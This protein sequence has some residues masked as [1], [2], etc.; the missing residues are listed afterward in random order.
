MRVS[1]LNKPKGL[2]MFRPTYLYIKTHNI[3]GLKYFG[4]TIK[5]PFKYKGSGKHWCAHLEKHGCD[6]TTEILGYYTNKEECMNAALE[7]SDKNKIVESSDWANMRIEM[8]DGGD[9]S[10]TENYIKW[11][12]RLIEEKKK[13]RWWNNGN[14]QT[15]NIAPPDES[16]VRGRLN[17]NNVGSK[18]GSEKLKGK[19]WVNNGKDEMMV[20]KNFISADFVAGRLTEK[21]FAGGEGRHSSKGTLWWN[22]GTLEKMATVCPGKNFVKGRISKR[23]IG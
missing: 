18:L 4:K 8:L 1:M 9:T 21:A 7:F 14:H 6:V 15:F 12:P 13:C 3:T 5:D 19:I 22:D 2:I 11:I 23:L 17:F 16:Y 20:D 10:K